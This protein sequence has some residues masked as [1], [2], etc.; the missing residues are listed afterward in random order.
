LASPAQP[1]LLDLLKSVS[2]GNPTPGAPAPAAAGQDS[3]LAS[4]SVASDRTA[5]TLPGPTEPGPTAPTMGTQAQLTAP[6][7][8]MGM[9]KLN[10]QDE[11]GP[12]PSSIALPKPDKNNEQSEQLAG[13]QDNPNFLTKLGRIAGGA[14]GVESPG[15]SPQAKAGSIA[16]HI[17]S[18]LGTAGA[19]AIGTPAQKQIAQENAQI[20]L[21]MQQMQ[22]EAGYRNAMVGNATNA[23]ATK[24]QNADTNTLK[25]ND[26]MRLKGYVPDEQHPGT[27]RSMNSDEILRD[28]Q[29]NQNQ[30]LREAALNEKKSAADL[31]EAKTNVAKNQNSQFSASL[32]QKHEQALAGLAMAKAHLELGERTLQNTENNQAVQQQSS[33]FKFNQGELNKLQLP[34]DQRVSRISNLMDTLG[35][36]TPQA[37]ALVA[38]ELLTT[39][40]GG[41]GSGLRMNEAEISRIVGGRTGW[42]DIKA[43]VN[44]WVAD[45]GPSNPN[46]GFA[47]T[48]PQREQVRNLMNVVSTRL[49][50]KQSLL[51]SAG[52]A[53]A[54]PNA[55]RFDHQQILANT[56]NQL[57]DIDGLT[58]KAVAVSPNTTATSA[59]SSAQP[60]SG[61]TVSLAAARALPINKGK[62]DAAITAD[63]K[64]HGHKVGQ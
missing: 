15:S 29:L 46:V 16:M 54:D 18:G 31:N 8:A 32:L 57:N 17:L 41:Q 49:A 11:A 55:T 50:S 27:F 5:P 36:N 38:P 14:F 40:A 22:N 47:L 34:I 26:T 39:M 24:Q 42:E 1:S 23:N 30:E 51:A 10:G 21:K 7:D 56:H 12:A 43:K 64:A 19:E 20:P 4:P 37:D 25:A 53:L 45:G 44:K 3:V 61:Q 60:S 62:S 52:Q 6:T 58:D 35:Q 13:S 9:S 59:R 28:P 33:S 2:A 48:G 63:I